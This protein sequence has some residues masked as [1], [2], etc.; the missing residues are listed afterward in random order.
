MT[1]P[2]HT[3]QHHTTVTPSKPAAALQMVQGGYYVLAGL[4]VALAI[5]TIQGPT[6]Y[7]EGGSNLWPVRVVAV[8]VAGLGAALLASGRTNAFTL[9]AWTGMWAALFLLLQT[10]A[11][12][13]FGVL[14]MTFLIDAGLEALFLG[15]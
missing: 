2:N 7:P 10:A 8:A 5:N 3:P 4:L 15:L 1:A 13:A 14:P 6:D 9:P 11:G 12:V